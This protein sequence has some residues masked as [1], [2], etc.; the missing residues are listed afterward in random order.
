M[1]TTSTSLQPIG[2][3]ERIYSLDILRG[4]VLLGILLMNISLFGLAKGDPSVAGGIEGINLYTWMTTNVFF[5]GTMR[6][7]FSLLFGVGMYVLTSRLE[8]QGGG[9]N[10]AD[11]YF[12]RTL[13]LMFFGLVHAYLL[14][15][16]SEILFDYGLIGLLI[17]SFRNMAPKKLV[18]IAVFLMICGTVWNYADYLSD[19]K[20]QEK[21]TL[22]QQHKAEGKE[23][24]KDLKAAYAKWEEDAY[25]HSTA[26]VT[27]YNENMRK[28][29]FSIV[30]FLAPINFEDD[31][32]YPYR[33]ALWDVMSMMLLGIAFFKW[34]ILSAERSYK[35]YLCMAVVG[36]VIGLL[37]NYYELQIMLNSNF[38]FVGFSRANLTFHC[39]RLFTAMGHLGF[40]MIFCKLPVLRRLKAALGA[41]GK[42]A[43]TNYLMHSIICMIF[44]TGVG[45]GMFGKL[46]RYELYYV[47]FAI[48]IFQLIVSPI[49]LSYFRFGPAE[50]LWRSLTYLKLQPMKKTM[51]PSVSSEEVL[52]L[53]KNHC[54]S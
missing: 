24:I 15:W 29:Y 5:E 31:T 43:L 6:G 27:D 52:S 2:Q 3:A 34:N 35:I 10:V 23:L 26:Y 46:Q 12:R 51:I 21:I 37:L 30:A 39:S 44:F 50:W 36:Y 41:V 53:L 25:K 45:F 47:V 38:S 22:A 20:L 28:G 1:K 18:L 33:S 17:F 8:K 49:W 7:L 42:M 19:L 40:I 48:W 14:L 11:I 9:V 13:W 4:I 16:Y 32:I 54:K